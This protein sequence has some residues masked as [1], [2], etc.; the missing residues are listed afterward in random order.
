MIPD[1][2][3]KIASKIFRFLTGFEAFVYHLFDIYPAAVFKQKN[4]RRSDR[5]IIGVAESYNSA[6][7]LIE[8]MIN[9]CIEAGKKTEDFRGYFEDFVREHT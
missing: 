6:T 9:E 3:L 4:I 7:G 5:V 8:Q 2:I 1:K